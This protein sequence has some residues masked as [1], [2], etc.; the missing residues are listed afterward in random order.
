MGGVCAHPRQS[1]CPPEAQTLLQNMLLVAGN[2]LERGHGKDSLSETGTPS[3]QRT[4]DWQ[5]LQAPTTAVGGLGGGRPGRSLRRQDRWR[6]GQ[7]SAQWL[8]SRSIQWLAVV[9]TK[10]LC[11][12]TGLQKTL[13]RL[14]GGWGLGKV[15]QRGQ[16]EKAPDKG[17]GSPR[18]G[19]DARTGDKRW[20][21]EGA[22][23]LRRGGCG[24][25]RD[26]AKERG[27]GQPGRDKS[28]EGGRV[29]G[30]RA[31]LAPRQRVLRMEARE[32]RQGTDKR[33]S[34]APLCGS[35]PSREAL[36]TSPGHSHRG[37]SPVPGKLQGF[38]GC[39]GLKSSPESSP[40]STP[41]P[42]LIRLI[43]ESLTRA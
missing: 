28:R 14:M 35:P 30:R 34:P 33:E 42:Q 39:A 15:K 21:R 29:C 6:W 32:P 16:G 3:L 8:A 40:P 9:Q 17:R 4:Q 38:H 13:P 12:L 20:R 26:A 27:R 41:V 11:I 43:F 18:P 10:Q 7:G 31:R 37:C 5:G 24:E 19:T 22:K 25:E 1:S 2:N 23:G 36:P